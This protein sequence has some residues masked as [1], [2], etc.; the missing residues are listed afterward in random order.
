MNLVLLE[1]SFKL[2][3]EAKSENQE[4]SEKLQF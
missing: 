3:F 2:Y 1:V 4:K